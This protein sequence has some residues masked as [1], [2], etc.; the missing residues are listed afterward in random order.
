[1]LSVRNNMPAWNAERQFGFNN[2]NNVK[3][4]EK[5]SSGYRINRGA[6]DAAGLSIS[7]K[8]RRQIRGLTQATANAQDGISLVQ[9]A[10]GALHEVHEMLHR[11][12]ELAIKAANGTLSDDDRELVDDEIQE[13]K[14]QIDASAHHT[15]F[16]ERKLFPDN[17]LSPRSG[18]VM[19][20]YQYEL[21]CNLQDGTIAVESAQGAGASGR[22]GVDVT[23]GSVLADKI[24]KEFVPNA[25]RQIF[26]AFPALE[27]ATGTTPIKL[28]LNVSFIDGPNNTL[29]YAQY[30][31]G[32]S[33]RPV[34]MMIKVDA[35][36]F[37][38][39]D[40]DGTGAKAEVLESTIAHELMHTVMQY[41]LTD[42]M[43]G[44]GGE[45]Y[46]TWF[47]EG[48]AQLAGGGFTTGW[49][50]TLLYYAKL[51]QS[52]QDDSQDGHIGD[53]LK[54][55]TM[56][57][58]P[59]GHGYLGA[60]YIGYLANGG[61]AVTGANIASGM[62]KVFTDLLAGKSLGD[63]IKGQT[64]K[65]ES[66][67]V[68]MFS[69]AD[70]DLV[71]FVR[72]LAYESKDGA[73]SVITNNLSEGGTSILG[74]TAPEQ[75]FGIDPSKIAIDMSGGAKL[76]IL[77]GTDA[78]EGQFIYIDLYQMD[79]EA[80]GIA[81][82]NVKTIEDAG[83]A[84][85][86]VKNAI[87]YV[88]NVRSQYGAIQNRLEHTMTNLNNIVENTTAAESRIRDTDMAEEMVRFSNF[89]ILLQAGQSM[90]AQANHQPDMLLSLLQ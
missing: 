14:A 60:A 1:M 80:L 35:A 39:A 77:V 59:Y 81:E 20:S 8:M 41:N 38:D 49:N 78:F 24:A 75:L 88:S 40:A 56:N 5:L 6:D 36:D 79:A 12:N 86:A 85:N 52:D 44:R 10:E 71:E 29:A 18:A 68:R 82:T 19:K 15:V 22:A 30:S 89:Q 67:I 31:Y 28:A 83:D 50:D 48:T 90:L 66:E 2:R 34:S 47:V 45:K 57:G 69:S 37:N 32:G 3:T 25:V 4:M 87:T 84:V 21:T 72:K 26:D 23:S 63:A 7:E 65:T 61:G 11:I 13:I 73:G 27:Q 9:S 76:G 64:G 17:G 74:A 70:K 54:R 43:S 33:G 51:L 53:Y 42:G 46:P 55:F 58:R 16:N 62:N